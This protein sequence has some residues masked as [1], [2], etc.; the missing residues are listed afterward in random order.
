MFPLLYVILPLYP[1]FSV[2]FNLMCSVKKKK[3]TSKAPIS[4]NQP[5]QALRS[6]LIHGD[7]IDKYSSKVAFFMDFN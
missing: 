7:T 3:R 2:L 1:V 6:W 5:P 4:C